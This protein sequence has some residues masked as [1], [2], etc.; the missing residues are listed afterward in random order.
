MVYLCINVWHTVFGYVWLSL[1]GSSYVTG[2]IVIMDVYY[3]PIRQSYRGGENWYRHQNRLLLPLMGIMPIRAIDGFLGLCYYCS[4]H[5]SHTCIYQHL[6]PIIHLILKT[7]I[8]PFR[9]NNGSEKYP[10]CKMV[11]HLKVNHIYFF[12][13]F[14]KTLYLLLLTYAVHAAALSG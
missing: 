1:D 6:L 12:R 5:K 2:D 4:G 9:V 10:N 8:A 14:L 11:L 7:I 3:R 13:V